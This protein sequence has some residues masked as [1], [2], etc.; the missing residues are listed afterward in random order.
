LLVEMYVFMI[1]MY[2]LYFYNNRCSTV[3]QM[4]KLRITHKKRLASVAFILLS[5]TAATANTLALMYNQANRLCIWIFAVLFLISAAAT[6]G[7][8]FF[9]QCKRYSGVQHDIKFKWTV[10]VELLLLCCGL[11]YGV[12]VKN[13]LIWL[14]PVVLAV[15]IMCPLLWKTAYFYKIRCLQTGDIL[16]RIYRVVIRSFRLC[17]RFFWLLL[18]RLFLDKFV[19]GVA[20]IF[21]H[22]CLRMFRRLHG[23]PFLG[24]L[25]VLLLLVGLLWLSHRAGGGLN[26]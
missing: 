24:G 3:S 23:K 14:T 21:S 9:Y 17:G 15:L 5:V 6:V 8:I 11:Q 19:L 7:Q 4:M 16:G 12:G 26:G 2:L 22:L 25:T 1:T 20:M 13:V 18:D 10:F